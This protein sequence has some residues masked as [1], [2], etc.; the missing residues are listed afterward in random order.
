MSFKVKMND[1]T[2]K[3]VKFWSRKVYST[4]FKVIIFAGR[5][6]SSGIKNDAFLKKVHFYLHFPNF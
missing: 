2:E 6:I 5:I 1:V 4:S 3:Y